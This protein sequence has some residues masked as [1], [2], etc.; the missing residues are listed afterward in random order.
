MINKK[1]Y[2]QLTAKTTCESFYEVLLL[3]CALLR[4][5]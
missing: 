1:E 2:K 3:F 4:K 5:R